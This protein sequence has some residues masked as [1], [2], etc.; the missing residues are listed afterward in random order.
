MQT[1][2]LV[3]HCT[4]RDGRKVSFDATKIRRAVSNCFA[5]VA[6]AQSG[7]AMTDN[8]LVDRIVKSTVAILVGERNPTPEVEH[9]QRVVI[10]QLWSHGLYEAAEHYQNYREERRKSRDLETSAVFGR[11]LAFKPFEY[12]D[13][14]QF[15]RAIQKSYWVGTEIDFTGD[16]QDYRCS[17]TPA[18]QHAIS[19]TVLAISQV[20]VSVK[21]FWTQLGSRLPRPEFE[22][23]GVVFGESEVR[24]ADAYSRL[25]DALRLNHMFAAVTQ[26]PAVRR[27]IEYMQTAMRRSA[28]GSDRDFAKSVAV[29]ALLVE[30]VSLF[31]QFVIAKSFSRKGGRL[32]N[33][34]NI[35]QATQKE[36]QVHALFGVW[37]TNLIR[38]ERPEWFGPGFY[39]QLSSIC[40]EAYS[41]ESAIVDWIFEEGA[42]PTVSR[43][44]LNAFLQD[45]INE[46]VSM[47][48]GHPVFERVD[49]SALAEVSWFGQEMTCPIDVDFFHKRGTNYSS[50]DT[51]TTADDLFS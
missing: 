21:R 48:G 35:V 49:R 8:P 9:V 40:L 28:G 25:L 20:E 43:A 42:C 7:D 6:G 51:T 5:A 3:T 44:A 23:V 2:D 45:R 31:S 33:I 1:S 4:K 26:V 30:N 46:G 17:L 15:K 37:L 39:E 32:Q 41:A 18:E 34:D 36:E 24:H 14:V 11:R 47:I 22:Q 29:F 50:L 38:K 10:S 12:E 27:R 19:R 16:V 13:T